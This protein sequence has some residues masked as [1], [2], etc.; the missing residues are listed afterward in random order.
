MLFLR[1]MITYFK[2]VDMNSLKYVL[3]L[4]FL[5]LKVYIYIYIRTL[6][7]FQ[8]PDILKFYG[9]KGPGNN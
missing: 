1:N 4:H 2:L 3:L 5:F 6:Y 8:Y 9:D 7:V